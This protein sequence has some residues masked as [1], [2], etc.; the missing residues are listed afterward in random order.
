MNFNKQISIIGATISFGQTHPGVSFGPEAI[1]SAGLTR[2]LSDL[3]LKIQDFG[4]VDA[5]CDPRTSSPNSTACLHNLGNIVQAN[6]QLCTK[7]ITILDQRNSFPLILGGD[8]SISI[9]IIAAMAKRVSNLGVIWFD[10]HPDLNTPETTPSGNIHG[11]PLAASLGL[12]HPKLVNIG[13]ICPKLS[14]DNVVIIG[15]R[16]MDSGEKRIIRRRGIKLYTMADVRRLGIRKVIHET[17]NYLAHRTDGIHLSIDLD[18]IDPIIAPGVGTP[19]PGGFSIR[20]CEIALRSL[21]QAGI[22]TSAD[23]VELNPQLD[24]E[25]QTASLA[26]ALV[27]FLLGGA[28]NVETIAEMA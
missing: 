13:G 28:G 26:V 27:S 16:T 11:M 10:A 8:H 17:T 22:I 23:I 25:N 7:L 5:K 21:F 12:G 20:E 24:K 18:G 14:A 19:V 4:D 1:R 15:A 2:E 9:G 6:K 3:G